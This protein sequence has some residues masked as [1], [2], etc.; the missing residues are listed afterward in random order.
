MFDHTATVAAYIVGVVG[1]TAGAWAAWVKGV[2]KAQADTIAALG[3]RLK[4][5]EDD[6]KDT[7]QVAASAEA[8]A[9]Q[10]EAQLAALARMNITPENALGIEERQTQILAEI[11][12]LEQQLKNLY[13]E[14]AASAEERK[15]MIAA[16]Q[17]LTARI[18][19]A[20]EQQPK[21]PTR[22]RTRTRKAD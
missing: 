13:E 19:S 11:S 12:A 8:R 18:I 16:V 4:A 3:T 17:Q 22:T 20:L 10:A 1:V 2:A 7:R 9:A 6:L 21:Q 14:L 5:V 15:L